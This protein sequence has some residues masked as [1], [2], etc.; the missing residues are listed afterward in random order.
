MTNDCIEGTL[1]IMYSNIAEPI[2]LGSSELVTINQLVD[3]AEQIAGVRLRRIYNLDAPR[4]VNGRNSDNTMILDRL[5]WQPSIRL[6]DGLEKTYRWIENQMCGRDV[7][8][9]ST[10]FAMSV[11]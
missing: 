6:R 4:G 3:V 7:R 8:P 10:H 2:N 9:S 5:E 1:R 11:A